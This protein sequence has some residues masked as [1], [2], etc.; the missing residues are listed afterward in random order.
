MYGMYHGHTVNNNVAKPT[1]EPLSVFLRKSI[2]PLAKTVPSLKM[3]SSVQDWKPAAH[4]NV[5]VSNCFFLVRC[6]LLSLT[7]TTAWA[8][9]STDS[10]LTSTKRRAPGTAGLT[11][12]LSAI[13]HQSD[14]KT[15]VSSFCRNLVWSSLYKGK[16]IFR[17]TGLS[18]QLSC[19]WPRYWFRCGTNKKHSPFVYRNVQVFLRCFL[20]ISFAILSCRISISHRGRLR[21]GDPCGHS[22]R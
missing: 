12:P 7:T 6:G 22:V 4:V 16:R 3:S 1:W 21:R 5:S 9:V 15:P 10:R 8:Q 20:V 11:S 17:R 14:A 13:S 18:D 19:A 2:L